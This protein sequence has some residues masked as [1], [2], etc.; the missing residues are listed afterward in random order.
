MQHEFQKTKKSISDFLTKSSNPQSMFLDPCDEHEIS[1][2]INTF[3]PKKSAGHDGLSMDLIKKIKN[4]IL[5]PLSL[6]M[7]I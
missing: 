7:N 4:G 1:K 3:K 5:L 2:I 6:I